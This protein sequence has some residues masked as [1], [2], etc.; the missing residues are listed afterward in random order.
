MKPRCEQCWP[1]IEQGNVEAWEVFQ[2]ASMDYMG[3]SLQGILAAC[4]IF[5]VYD[6]NECI[7]KVR[8]LTS[9]IRSLEDKNKEHEHIKKADNLKKM[10]IRN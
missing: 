3:I 6:I 5:A 8:E 2:Y 7:Q 1:G 9:E 10:A 4:E